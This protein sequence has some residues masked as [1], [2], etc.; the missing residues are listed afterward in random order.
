MEYR[1]VKKTVNEVT[2]FSVQ[3]NTPSNGQWVN[4]I[5]GTYDNTPRWYTLNIFS[6]IEE[7]RTFLNQKKLGLQPGETIVT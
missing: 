5:G 2:T 7:A 4:N 1:I 3:T 6:T